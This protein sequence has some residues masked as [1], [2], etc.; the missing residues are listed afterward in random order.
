M[1]YVVYVLKSGSESEVVRATLLTNDQAEKQKRFGIAGDEKILP[2]DA[3]ATITYGVEIKELTFDDNDSPTKI[4][5]IA[6]KPALVTAQQEIER[7][8]SV[9]SHWEQ[10]E[11]D[12]GKAASWEL[13]DEWLQD[14][15][16]LYTRRTSAGLISR[17]P[18][19]QG[20][21]LARRRTTW[22]WVLGMW[23][24]YVKGGQSTWYEAFLNYEQIGLDN[25][26]NAHNISVWFAELI[27]A[28]VGGSA[29]KNPATARKAYLTNAV[30]GGLGLAGRQIS[31][32]FDPYH[33]YK[34]V[35]AGDS[36]NVLIP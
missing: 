33:A 20:D 15:I 14:R 22:V 32:Q 29:V 36:K 17:F 10:F 9:K 30:T 5:D 28:T 31:Q 19:A 16:H 11:R 12:F 35:A 1:P 7:F 24:E 2:T 25:W 3:A 13:R 23:Y 21:V 27:N 34:Y 4:T 26:Y 6:Y 18:I 8:Y